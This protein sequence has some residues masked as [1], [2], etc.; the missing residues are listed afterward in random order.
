[1]R[2]VAMFLLVTMLTMTGPIASSGDEI[3]WR[4]V[5]FSS[6]QQ[7]VINILGLSETGG[8]NSGSILQ[9]KKPFPNGYS[10]IKCEF[11]GDS[12]CTSNR[13][14]DLE[15]SVVMPKCESEAT[16]WCIREFSAVD[17]TGLPVAA[18]FIKYVEGSG[19]PENS[20][21]GL[22]V[23]GRISI[24]RLNTQKDSDPLYYALKLRGSMSWITS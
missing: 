17:A 20:E 18:T 24:W 10:P 3:E 23:G 9:Y 5:Q 13:L 4:P 15:A 2:K 8:G 1:M 19:Y 6:T 16:S 7:Y 14:R 22:P 11:Y 12:I 21:I